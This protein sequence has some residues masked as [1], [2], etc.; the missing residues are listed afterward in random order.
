MNHGMNRDRDSS[1]APSRKDFSKPQPPASEN[2]TSATAHSLSAFVPH[3]RKLKRQPKS[4]VLVS[5][6]KLEVR[7]ARKAMT[8][9]CC[10]DNC[11]NRQGR[12]TKVS[13]HRFPHDKKKYQ[14]WI[15]AIRLELNNPCWLPQSRD[16]RICGE[17]FCDREF[18]LANIDKKQLKEHAYPCFKVLIRPSSIL[19]SLLNRPD[20]STYHSPM[21]KIISRNVQV[22]IEP[23]I[24]LVAHFE[25]FQNLK[26]IEPVPECLYL[27]LGKRVKYKRIR[28]ELYATNM[29]NLYLAKKFCTS[30]GM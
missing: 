2:L 8:H 21:P 23:E 4:A 3:P 29:L 5:G 10:I 1:R 30:M 24:P 13:Y 12:I 27:G 16:V 18:V 26:V 19:S 28:A 7:G 15:K 25:I 14:K 20:Q 11:I 6:L 22:R 17:H 9:C